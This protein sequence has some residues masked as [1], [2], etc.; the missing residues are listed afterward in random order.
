MNLGFI[1]DMDGTIVDNMHYHELAWQAVL[2]ERGVFCTLHEVQLKAYGNS[3]EAYRRFFNKDASAEELE[4]LSSHK[5][6]RYRQYFAPHF[7]PI[8][9]LVPFMEKAHVLGIPLAIA[10]G[11]I[12]ENC[13]WIVDKLG[14]RALLTA[15]VTA[16]DVEH[17]KP[18]PDTFLR[19]AQLID[20]KPESCIVF[21]DVPSGGMAAFNGGMRSVILTTTY[22]AF[23]AATFAST[24]KVIENYTQVTPEEF[25]G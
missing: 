12:R 6:A 4:D 11:S 1:L 9:G 24:I 2:A 13:D 20:I 22:P 16:D 10:T 18:N 3:R 15:I 5:E 7:A 14:V 25:L 19:A 17:G 23:V 8:N 21:E